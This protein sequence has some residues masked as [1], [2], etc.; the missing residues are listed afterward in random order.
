[1][2]TQAALQAAG[3]SPVLAKAQ[4]LMKDRSLAI[5]TGAVS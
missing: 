2:A 3:S 5:P 4:K 1:M